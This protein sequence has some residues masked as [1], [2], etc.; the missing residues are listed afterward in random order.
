MSLARMTIHQIYKVEGSNPGK[1]KNQN[2]I[3]ISFILTIKLKTLKQKL[4]KMHALSFPICCIIN[5]KLELQH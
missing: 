1:K 5:K 3:K 2:C 4:N